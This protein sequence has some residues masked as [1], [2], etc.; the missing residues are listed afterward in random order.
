MKHEL[1]NLDLPF[2]AKSAGP[3]WLPAPVVQ[4][5]E[6]AWWTQWIMALLGLVYIISGIVSFFTIESSSAAFWAA[7][8]LASGVLYFVVLY[9]MKKLIFDRIDQGKFQDGSN[10]LLV[11][12]LIGLFLLFVPGVLLLISYVILRRVFQPSY[13]S[14]PAGANQAGTTAPPPA[15]AAP[16]SPPPSQ[17]AP[18][19]PQEP[20]QAEQPR[21]TEMVKCKKCGV[22]YPS[23]MRTCPNCNEPR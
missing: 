9:F 14:Y 3:P 8:I 20:A 2:M 6:L 4:A 1:D 19:P 18:P 7:Y 13:Q 12:G 17:P 10:W 15:Q 16:Q 11:F 5:R 22:Q 21:K 23:F